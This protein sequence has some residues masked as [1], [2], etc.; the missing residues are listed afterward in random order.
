MMTESRP[1]S[2][3]THQR[4]ALA[5]QARSYVRQLCDSRTGQIASGVAL[6]LGE[7][8]FIA[9]VAHFLKTAAAP[10]I[11]RRIDEPQVSG[12]FRNVV[13]KDEPDVGLIELTK[14]QAD[15]IKDW[16]GADKI[17]VDHLLTPETLVFV[18]GFP[19]ATLTVA[20]P[21]SFCYATTYATFAASLVDW[22]DRI[23]DELSK[24][25]D[26]LLE[27]AEE[28][29]NRTLG[30]GLPLEGTVPE[31]HAPPPP[32]GVSGGAV[33]LPVWNSQGVH[34]ADNRL[35]GI[36]RSYYPKL[37]LLRVTLI[38]EWLELALEHYPELRE[39]VAETRGQK[40]NFTLLPF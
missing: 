38:N 21:Y 8:H 33:W 11:V 26:L 5:D 1:D 31:M 9:T 28:T 29:E 18:V 2:E 34:R 24:D 3:R 27:L 36:Q 23:S 39:Q 32:E 16:M 14:E 15:C 19:S 13:F 6:R 25:M 30:P 12:E 10:Q 7:R 37:R 4:V 20:P 17:L 40:P 22:A 35:I